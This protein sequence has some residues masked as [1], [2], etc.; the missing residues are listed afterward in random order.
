[1][2]ITWN[3]LTVDPDDVDLELLLSSW[4]WLVNEEYQPVVIS[5]LGD[6]FLCHDNGSV[7]WLDT[8]I[9]EL[10]E[11]ASSVEEFQQLIVVPENADQWFIPQLVG[12]LKTVGKNLGPRQCYSYVVPPILGG[13]IEVDNFQVMDLLVHV[14]VLGQI[15]EQV[16]DLPPGTPISKIEIDWD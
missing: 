4:R 16:K 6:I 9:G 3:D 14:D 12:D 2:R 15:H 1:M 5:A 11:V 10:T 7:H 13:E 8:G